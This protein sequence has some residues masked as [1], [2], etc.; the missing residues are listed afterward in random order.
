MK[1]II[2]SALEQIGEKNSNSSNE[3]LKL[4][5]RGRGSGYKEGPDQVE[6]E[7]ELHLCISAKDESVYNYACLCVEKLLQNVYFEYQ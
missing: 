3:I 7:E 5:L 2:E 4:R 1:K 6:S